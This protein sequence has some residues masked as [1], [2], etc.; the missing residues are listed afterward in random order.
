MDA[1]NTF[2]RPQ[3]VNCIVKLLSTILADTANLQI[4]VMLPEAC[5]LSRSQ[6]IVDAPPQMPRYPPHPTSRYPPSTPSL[7]V[8]HPPSTPNTLSAVSA[9]LAYVMGRIRNSPALRCPWPWP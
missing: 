9:G 7:L 3:D 5:S 6:W 2:Q 8:L 1:C 4:V